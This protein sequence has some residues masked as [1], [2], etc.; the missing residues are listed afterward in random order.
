[1]TLESE[2]PYPNWLPWLMWGLAALFYCYENLLQVS[3]GVMVPDLMADF[4]IHAAAL[5]QLSAMYFYAYSIMQIPAGIFFDRI[6]ARYC[7]TTAVLAVALGSL[8]FGD[9][10]HL[11]QASAGR[12]LVGMGSAAAAVGC[13]T[14]ASQY[15]PPKRFALVFGS[16]LSIGMLGSVTGQAPLSLAIQHFGWRPVMSI[17]GW[18]GLLLA[19]AIWVTVRSPGSSEDRKQNNSESHWLTG[20]MR[21]IRTPQS[22]V[23]AAYAGLMFTPTIVI[24]SLWGVPYLTQYYHIEQESAAAL[25][26]SI[27]FGWIVGAPLFGHLSDHLKR[28]K[29]PLVIGSIGA[30]LAL[31]LIVHVQHL[32]MYVMGGALFSVGLFSS[33]FLPAFSL[34]KE[35]HRPEVSSTAFGY[36]NTLN[37]IGGA[38]CQPIVG[39]LLDQSWKKHHGSIVAGIRQYTWHDY[40]IAL[41]ALPVFVAI[42][43]ILLPWIK[44]TYCRQ[45]EHQPNEN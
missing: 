3:A 11:W 43:C 31:L 44:E 30:L 32:P 10:T 34:M 24:G 37:M 14:I 17:S 7:L 13:F 36:M 33:G 5:G 9:A 19:L 39:I 27:Y 12:F 25:V 40:H 4:N 26:S 38:A 6:C 35:I 41:T 29:P 28:R 20:L 2:K 21:V 16:M 23:I 18:F 22:W 8:I 1:M 42:A 45:M 15:L